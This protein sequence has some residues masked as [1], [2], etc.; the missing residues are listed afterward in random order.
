MNGTAKTDCKAQKSPDPSGRGKS[1]H[2]VAVAIVMLAFITGANAVSDI[3]G[4]PNLIGIDLHCV[5][6]LAP[7][8]LPRKFC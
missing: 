6:D 7:L 8:D 5:V 4:S 2:L 3:H 1:N